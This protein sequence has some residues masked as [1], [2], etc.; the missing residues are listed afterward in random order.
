MT[1]LMKAWRA[2]ESVPDLAE[3][4]CV[5]KELAG[6]EFVILEAYLRPTQKLSESYPC[7]RPGGNGCPRR[8]VRHSDEDIVAVCGCSPRECDTVYLQKSDLIIYELDTSKFFSH[9]NAFLGFRAN[10][11]PVRDATRTWHIGDYIPT[12]GKSFSV[13]FVIPTDSTDLSDTV[14]ALSCCEEHEFIVIVT[15]G[16]MC[17]PDAVER[18]KKKNSSLLTLEDNLVVDE[19]GKIAAALTPNEILAEFNSNV[20]PSQDEKTSSMIIFDTPPE[21][22]WGDVMIRF[23]DGY[24]VTVTV[25]GKSATLNFAQMGMVNRRNSEPTVQWKL[26]WDFAYS[27]GRILAR[28]DRRHN[29]KQRE[30]LAKALRAFFRIDGDVFQLTDD[31]KGWEPCFVLLPDSPQTNE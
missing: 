15:T 7:P 19:N 5:W 31:G 22:C 16:D 26:L 21:A 29:S 17:H 23:L 4:L 3:L 9:I 20:L 28:N 27:P 25:K 6:D 8:V 13:Y 2:L 11:V 12:A 1:G 24:R 18:L 30:K 10:I 14:N